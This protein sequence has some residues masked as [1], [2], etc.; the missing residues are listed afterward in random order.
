MVTPCRARTDV[1][2]RLRRLAN[3]DD[4]ITRK[5][6][7]TGGM[8]SAIDELC[9]ALDKKFSACFKAAEKWIIAV[10]RLWRLLELPE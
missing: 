6:F 7:R 9:P 1:E 2:R 4:L 5:A 10:V 8:L 3:G